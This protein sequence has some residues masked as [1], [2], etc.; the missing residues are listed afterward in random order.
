M[1]AI[2]LTCLFSIELRA[3]ALDSCYFAFTDLKK[4]VFAR[5]SLIF[6][7]TFSECVLNSIT[8]VFLENNKN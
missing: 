3:A 5:N 6:G 4:N 2:F 7:K 1:E 8:R